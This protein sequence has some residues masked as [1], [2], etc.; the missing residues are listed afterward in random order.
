MVNGYARAKNS[1]SKDDCNIS[2]T[3][4]DD[5]ELN[6]L[7]QADSTDK[8]GSSCPW[9]DYFYKIH[10]DIE[11]ICKKIKKFEKTYR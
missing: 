3:I 2:V 5:S 10:S 4:E 8:V 7:N 1:I 11:K 6:L 9:L